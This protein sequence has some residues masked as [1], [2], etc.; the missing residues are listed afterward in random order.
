MQNLLKVAACTSLLSLGCLEARIDG[1]DGRFDLWVGYRQDDFDWTIS[2]FQ[3]IPNIE[4]EINWQDMHAIEV[5]SRWVLSGW[6]HFYIRLLGDYAW[7]EQLEA[8][9]SVYGSNNRTDLLAESVACRSGNYLLD[10]SGCVGYHLIRFK[11]FFDIAPVVGYSFH[12]QSLRFTRPTQTYSFNADNIGEIPDLNSRYR[13][14]W[15]G[16]FGG[17]DAVFRPN[18]C[19]TIIGELEG[20]YARCRAQGKWVWYDS[21]L[22][23]DYTCSEKDIFFAEKYMDCTSG[24]GK[25]LR[26]AAYYATGGGWSIGLTGGYQSFIGRKGQHDV[27]NLIDNTDAAQLYLGTLPT[28]AANLDRIAWRSYSISFTFHCAF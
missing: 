22:A 2:G 9:Y 14:R 27:T 28:T 18:K 26:L 1:Y 17:F 19:I 24:W 3:G 13:T 5:G 12:T 8:T 25:V 16:V 7:I 21:D 20:H 10:L 4:A 11:E 23:Y 15:Q 6:D